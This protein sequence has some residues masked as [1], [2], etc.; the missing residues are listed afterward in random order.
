MDWIRWKEQPSE[1][2]TALAS[3]VLPIPGTSSSRTCP[4]QKMA[5]RTSS[6]APDLPTM[7]RSTLSRHTFASGRQDIDACLIHNP[8]LQKFSH[9]ST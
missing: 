3:M 2:A 5:T 4:S 8:S 1:R 9:Y 7:T 6:T